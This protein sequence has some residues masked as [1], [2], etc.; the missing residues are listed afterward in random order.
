[1][2]R[3]VVTGLG[4]ITPIGIGKE[5]YWKSLMEGRSGISRITNFDPENHASQIAGEVKDF[6]PEDYIERKEAKRMDRFS[7]F[8]VAGAMLAVEDS[9]IDIDSLDKERVGVILGSGVGGIET[10]EK[11][12][13]K[14]V[15]KGPRRVSPFF[16]PMMIANMGP[17]HITML[18]D[19]RGP[20]FTITTA[21]AS[22]T[23]A[24]GESFKLIQ[25]GTCDVVVTGGSEAAV[26]PIAVAGFSSMRALSTR[27]EE[28]EKACRPFDKDRDG[29]IIGEGAGILIL[30]ELEH[31]LK[32]GAHIY[33]EVVGY[34]ATSDAYHIT[35]PDPEATGAANSIKIALEDG[36]V[37]YTQVDYINA[38][39]TS[40]YYNDKLETLAIKKV[41]KEHA[42]KISISSTKSMTGHLLGAAG[43][44]EA[45][46]SVLAIENSKIPP[47]IN[48][49]TFDSECDLDY[50]PN[51]P[52]DREV[53]YAL[54]NSLGFGGHNG[55]IIFKKYDK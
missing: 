19:F 28:P 42:S 30:E 36:Q 1:M 3:V 49:E 9:E 27:N 7:Q 10:L 55:T 17:G 2:R 34:G 47:T 44:I 31:A 20:S 40:T 53:R 16:I 43:G 23:H 25:T 13:S 45:I 35:A 48:Y 6:N 8:A 51:K 52:V 32:R 46:A 33:G 4:P 54:S 11:E 21:C 12:H 37:D 29:F 38:H 39:G 22:G 5:N 41:F 18:Y 26:S 14:L 50:T 24:I 15:E